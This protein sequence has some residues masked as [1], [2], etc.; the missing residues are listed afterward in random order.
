MADEENQV[1]DIDESVEK[2]PR[3]SRLVMVLLI[4]VGLLLLAFGLAA[5][6]I[7]GQANAPYG[8]ASADSDVDPD[9]SDE[10][11]SEDEEELDDEETEEQ[12]EALYISLRPQFTVNFHDGQKERYLMASIDL[13]ARD[14]EIIDQIEKDMPV[15]RYQILRVL[16][17][18]DGSLFKEGGKDLLLSQILEV[19]QTI[20]DS[21]AG[22][23]EAVYLTS[24]VVQ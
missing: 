8:I 1:D 19:I 2:P 12:G 22:S 10:A 20:I 15:V 7:V 17:R 11:A 5:G 13:M 3:G 24:F 14:Q 4:V 16:G 18:Q 23:V 9:A 21:P 6:Y